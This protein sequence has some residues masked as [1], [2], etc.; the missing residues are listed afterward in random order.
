M[1]GARHE[2]HECVETPDSPLRRTDQRRQRSVVELRRFYDPR[3][4]TFNARQVARD[5]LLAGNDLLIL[6]RDAIPGRPCQYHP[7]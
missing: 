3:E 6:P 2:R 1:I 4:L 7:I 5:A